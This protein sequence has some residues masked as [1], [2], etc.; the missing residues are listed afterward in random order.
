MP[1]EWAASVGTSQLLAVQARI[2]R[3]IELSKLLNDY[4]LSG[5]TPGTRAP[6]EERGLGCSGGMHAW[7]C[8]QGRRSGEGHAVSAARN[9]IDLKLPR[10]TAFGHCDTGR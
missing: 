5:N 1:P 7:H 9:F 8:Q 6:A 10:M 2:G 3:I 4:V